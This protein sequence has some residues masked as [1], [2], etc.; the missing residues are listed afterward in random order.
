MTLLVWGT[1]GGKAEGR[2]TRDVVGN[3]WL[4]MGLWGAE[5][6]RPAGTDHVGPLS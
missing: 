1:A 2:T 5:A 6:R 3:R 4:G